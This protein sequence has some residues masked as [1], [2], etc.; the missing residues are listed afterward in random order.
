MSQ[1]SSSNSN[2]RHSW[3]SVTLQK[4]PRHNGSAGLRSAL[5]T[6]QSG[7]QVPIGHNARRNERTNA[8]A[9]E[10]KT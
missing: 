9:K 5:A 1:L 8:R 7:C 4:K 6:F 10:G 2:V 3:F